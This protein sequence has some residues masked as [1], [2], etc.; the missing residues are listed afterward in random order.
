M[1]T[2]SPFPA[3]AQ[4]LARSMIDRIRA[5]EKIPLDETLAFLTLAGER[6][7]VEVKNKNLPPKATDV[8]FF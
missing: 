7:V 2:P 4:D 3:D 6:L 5:G 1:A 8:D